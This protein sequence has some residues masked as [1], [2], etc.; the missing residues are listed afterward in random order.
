MAVSWGC[1]GGAVAVMLLS[2][3]MVC[4]CCVVE[5]C[6]VMFC[7]VLCCAVLCYTPVVPLYTALLV[8]PT[9]MIFC[10]HR[11]WPLSLLYSPFTPP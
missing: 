9:A 3:A 10:A 7:A 5:W 2:C 11:A 1:C 8:V 6:G 4:C